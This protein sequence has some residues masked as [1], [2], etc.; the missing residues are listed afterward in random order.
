MRRYAFLIFVALAF[1]AMAVAILVRAASDGGDEQGGGWGGRATPVAVHTVDV[2]GFA[3]IVEAL[4]T[5]RANESVTITAKVSDVIARLE[6]D[7]GDQVEAGQILVELADAEEA[8]GLS[9]ARATL[10]ET[11]RDV[12]RIRDLTERG[13][14]PR[15]RLDEAVAANERAR[16]RVNAIEARV[17]DRIIRAPFSGVVGLRNVSVGELVRPGDVIAQLDDASV[18]K[19]DFT[20]PE[21]FLAVIEPG[22]SVSAVSAAFPDDV[23][24]G[25]VDQ[26]DTRI[27][28]ATRAVT[29]RAIIDNADGRIRPG[30]LMTVEMRRAERDQTAVPGSAIVRFQ[31]DTFVFVVEESERGA[32]A[33]RRDVQLGQRKNGVVEVIAGLEPGE[34]VVAEGVHR[35]RDGGVVQLPQGVESGRGGA[36]SGPVSSAGGA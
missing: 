32:R 24:D 17:A 18:I 28:P 14:A 8:A 36:A 1:A 31:D 35:V 5:A 20:V 30:M 33:V 19:L 13:V 27:D 29:V 15:S 26:V 21:R 2:T 34:V 11:A 16:A 23:F 25:V 4:G 9:E 10:R 12:E 3:D 6:F 22:L 7:S